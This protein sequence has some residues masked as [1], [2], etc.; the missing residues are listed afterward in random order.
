MKEAKK[1]STQKKPSVRSKKSTA[2][3]V[4]ITAQDPD[5]EEHILKIAGTKGL[6]VA[7]MLEFGPMKESDIIEKISAFIDK[8]EAHRVL[9][10]M[11][12]GKVANYIEEQVRIPDKRNPWVQYSWFLTLD[13]TLFEIYNKEEVVLNNIHNTIE[14]EKTNNFYCCQKKCMKMIF[15][16]A[17]SAGFRCPVCGEKMEYYE[18]KHALENLKMA[19]SIQKMHCDEINK[20]CEICNARDTPLRAEHKK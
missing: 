12:D 2:S 13:D 10:A 3:R 8:K 7:Q 15:D 14:Y 16:D 17:Y 4:R 6:M 5:I 19:E 11:R 20:R 1:S 18:N 9:Y